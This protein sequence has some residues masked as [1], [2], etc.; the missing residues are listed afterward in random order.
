MGRWPLA[1]EQTAAFE[2]GELLAS[3]IYYGL[4]AP[5]GNGRLVLLIPG[6]LGADGYLGLLANW[7]GRIGYRPRHSGI[8]ITAGSLPSL[9]RH[10][11]DRVEQ[12]AMDGQ[13]IT[14]IGHSIG[15]VFGRMAAVSDPTSSSG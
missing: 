13:R 10:T 7:L 11:L 5:K 1:L 4:G 6:F 14:I 3:P 15:G 8:V 12:L 9:L 2:L